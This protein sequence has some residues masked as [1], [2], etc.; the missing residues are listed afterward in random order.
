[1]VSGEFGEELRGSS[2][3]VAIVLTQS[4]CPQWLW[5]RQYL[6][7]VAESPG[8]DVYWMEYDREDSFEEFLSFK[9]EVLGNR[10][11]PYIRYYREGALRRES[12]YIDK[13][14]FLRMFGQ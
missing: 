6:P 11:I 1:M 4:W 10:E 8:L 3:R 9:E 13:A 5:M 7:S 2:G 14:G 12:N